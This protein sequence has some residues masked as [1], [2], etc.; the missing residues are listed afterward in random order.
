MPDTANLEDI[1][2]TASK[3][4]DDEIVPK[5]MERAGVDSQ[6]MLDA[7]YRSMGSSLRRTRENWAQN[8][9]VKYMVRSKIN[10]DPEVSHR[11]IYDTYISERDEKWTVN[12][13]VRWERLAVRFDRFTTRQQ[14]WDALAEMGNEVVYGAPFAAVSKRKSQDPLASKGGE[15]GWTHLGSLADKNLE[16][17]LF[18]IPL[19][20]LSDILENDRGLEIVRVIEREEAGFISFE[21]AQP[22]IRK[23]LLEMKQEAEF[24]RYAEKVRERV[25]V[26]IFD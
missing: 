23:R 10:T 16:K 13:R 18:S 4:F 12:A 20:E 21:K 7:H 17:Q 19:D 26:E 8:E 5:L 22:Q 11:E 25:P 3:Q 9:L 1:L 2:E 14:A 24:Q 15:Q 6:V